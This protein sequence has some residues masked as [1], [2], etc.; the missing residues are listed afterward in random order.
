MWTRIP[1]KQKFIWTISSVRSALREMKECENREI[2][3]EWNYAFLHA[4]TPVWL[5]NFGEFIPMFSLLSV[6]T[7]SVLPIRTSW[8]QK[9]LPFSETFFQLVKA[10]ELTRNQNGMLHYVRTACLVCFPRNNQEKLYVKRHRCSFLR[11]SLILL[12][13]NMK[14]SSWNLEQYV[15]CVTTYI[16]LISFIKVHKI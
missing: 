6:F 3:W 13:Y 11:N 16:L 12:K 2:L 4:P 1:I 7:A 8:G 14:K 10:S 5:Q 9:V 15:F